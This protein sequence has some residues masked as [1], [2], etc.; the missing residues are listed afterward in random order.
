MNEIKFND[1]DQISK[2]GKTLIKCLTLCQKNEDVIVLSVNSGMKAKNHLANFVI[3][4]GS[5][6]KK[7]KEAPLRG[8]LEIEVKG[9]KIVIGRGIASK[10]LVNCNKECN[11]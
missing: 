5:I 8:P 4:P 1:S 10:I 3:V 2:I 7:K 6:I 9:S 11:I